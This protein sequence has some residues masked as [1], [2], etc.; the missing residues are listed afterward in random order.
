[1]FASIFSGMSPN[2]L[3]ATYTEQQAIDY[4][5]RNHPDLTISR[6][7]LEIT[8]DKIEV[9][10]TARLPQVGFSVATKYA[11]NPLDAFSDKLYAGDIAQSD[12]DPAKLN[13]PSN[14]SLLIGELSLKVPVYD[15]GRVGAQ[16]K[17]ARAS[18][19][20]TQVHHKHRAKV[21]SNNAQMAYIATANAMRAISILDDALAAAQEHAKTTA[22]LVKAGRIVES[23]KLTAELNLNGLQVMHEQAKYRLEQAKTRLKWA[24][25]LDQ[26]VNIEVV[27]EERSIPD[28]LSTSIEEQIKLAMTQRQDLNA[29]YKQADSYRAEAE[30][31]AMTKKPSINLVASVN[32]YQ[33]GFAPDTAAWRIM[34]VFNM[35][36]YEG[37]ATA[38]K[39]ALVRKMAEVSNA[40]AT[41]LKLRIR[42]ELQLARNQISEAQA[43]IKVAKGNVEKAQRNVALIKKRYGQ[44][45]TILIELLQA[46]RLLLESRNEA[47]SAN[48]LL[49]AGI[50]K[51]YQVQGNTL[52][53]LEEGL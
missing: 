7:Q 10:K 6:Q 40:S 43:R 17:S 51:L 14:S 3:A 45:R 8:Q 19:D 33:D 32:S 22:D 53:K 12:F 2:L 47:L 48:H 35:P 37:G 49:H 39:T 16:I 30:M 20:V 23:D 4:A 42:N 50:A 46:E 52:S 13:D 34:G 25:G 15:W 28:V 5:L 18:Y 29:F 11:N 31:V 26:G 24:M 9:V 44:G 38:K 41:S 21:I 1:M 36:L 27:F